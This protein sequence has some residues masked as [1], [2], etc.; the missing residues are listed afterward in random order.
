MHATPMST[1]AAPAILVPLAEATDRE[2]FGHKAGSLAEL[3]GLGFDVPA[4]FVLPV[5]ATASREELSRALDALGGGPVAVRSS[6]IAEDLPEASFAGQYDTVL[7][8]RGV[9]DVLAAIATCV[10]SATGERVA[11]YRAGE[12][13]LAVLVQK[14]VAAEASGVAF[15]ANPLTGARDE[16]RISATRGTGERLVS[17]ELDGDE[18]SVKRGIATALREPQRAIDGPLALRIA[19]LASKAEQA[20]ALPQDIEWAVASGS[21]VLLQSRPITVLPVPPAIQTPEGTW[22][23]DAAHFPEPVSPFAAS[24]HLH[25]DGQFSDP[26][27]AWGLMPDGVRARVIGHEFYTHVEPDDGGKDPPPWWILALAVRLVPS[28]RAKL[29]RAEHAVSSG[30]LESVPAAWASEDRPRLWSAIE[31]HAAVDLTALDDGALFAHLDELRRFATE[32]MKLHFHLF[33]PYCVGVHELVATCRQLLGHRTED[34]MRLLQGC[35]QTS[36]AAS[37]ALSRIAQDP[38]LGREARAVLA[39]RGPDFLTRLEGVDRALALRLRDYLRVWG[40]RPLGSEAGSPSV[41]ERPELVASML[42][43]ALDGVAARDVTSA[44]SDAVA[45]ASAKLTDPAQRKRFDDAL[46]FARRVYPLREDNV[47]LTDQLPTGLLRR[48]ALEVGR[49]L[50]ERGQLARM[51]DAVMLTADELRGAVESG[52]DMR[53]VVRQRKAEH[54]W[55][56]GNPGPMLYG[57]PPGKMPDLRGLP[58][59]ARRINAALLFMMDEE[60][61]AP[62]PASGGVVRGLGVSPGVHRGRVRVVRSAEQL[63][64]LERGEVLVCPITSAAWMLVFQRAGALVTDAGSVLSHTAIV[65]REFGLPAVVGTSNATQLLKDGDEVTVDGSRGTVE[66]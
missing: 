3:L 53:P 22:Q 56:R 28:L 33:V 54:A 49:R 36:C 38:T 1:K 6:G 61:S 52:C 12:R 18:W 51:Q 47:L 55:V 39:A 26:I 19:E 35:S 8:V 60:L 7:D 65:A 13:R 32:C 31:R 30:W 66:R 50:I 34:T 2:R 43:D 45:E 27:A 37:E 23:K 64:R 62:P 15:S 41:A 11:A 58:E 59:P 14:M 29:K 24:T 48:V 16:V 9:D 4:G 42:A 46:A 57:P 5:G 17:G 44:Q 21:L 63:G 40:L 10:A 25:D 20:R